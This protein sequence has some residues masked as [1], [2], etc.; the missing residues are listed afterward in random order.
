MD[1]FVDEKHN[2]VRRSVRAFCERELM[3][4]AREARGPGPGPGG[5]PAQAFG[6]PTAARRPETET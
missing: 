6:R 2:A 5:R 1:V 4:I 3:P